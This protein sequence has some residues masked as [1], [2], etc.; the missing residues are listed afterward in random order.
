MLEPVCE[1][2]EPCS[3]CE[4]EVD[5]RDYLISNG[6]EGVY[7]CGNGYLVAD[8]ELEMGETKIIFCPMCGKR[9]NW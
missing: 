7:I 2:K 8:D 4:V 1:I 9:L 3:Y 5:A 6:G